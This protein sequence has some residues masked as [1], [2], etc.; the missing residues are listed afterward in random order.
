MGYFEQCG[1]AH[2]RGDCFVFDDRVALNPQ[3]E[4]TATTMCFSCREPLTAADRVSPEFKLGERCPFC[5]KGK[6]KRFHEEPRE[7]RGAEAEL[8]A[9]RPHEAEE[10][11]EHS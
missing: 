3:L 7:C 1:G 10:R 9:K 6:K 4:E 8:D 11:S 2:W 5:V